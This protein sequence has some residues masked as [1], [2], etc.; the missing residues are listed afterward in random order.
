MPT[1]H[2]ASRRTGTTVTLLTEYVECTAMP[3]LGHPRVGGGERSFAPT[4]CGVVPRL[5]PECGGTDHDGDDDRD[6]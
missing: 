3:V 4:I 6:K 5:S 1:G 2:R